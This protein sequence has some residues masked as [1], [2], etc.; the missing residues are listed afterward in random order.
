MYYKAVS[1]VAKLNIFFDIKLKN[2][3]YLPK[4]CN[5]GDILCNYST[6]I[7]L[8]FSKTPPLSHFIQLS[9]PPNPASTSKHFGLS[10]FNFTFYFLTYPFSGEKEW[11]RYN[12]LRH[13]LNL[14]N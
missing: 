4:T 2:V 5:K 11:R 12:R 13:I 6:I 3:K 8:F 7:S 10:R 14:K 9:K 1:V